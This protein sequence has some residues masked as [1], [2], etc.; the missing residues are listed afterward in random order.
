MKETLYLSE[1]E[2]TF[3]VETIDD[4]GTTMAFGICEMDTTP[5]YMDRLTIT[6]DGA[7]YTLSTQVEVILGEP[8]AVYGNFNIIDPLASATDPTYNGAHEDTGEPF[9][10]MIVDNY[11]IVFYTLSSDSTHTISVSAITPEFLVLKDKNGDPGTYP[12][13]LPIVIPDDSGGQQEYIRGVLW[14]EVPFE[15]YFGSDESFGISLPYGLLTNHIVMSKPENL[16]PENIATGVEIAGVTGTQAKRKPETI[17]TYDLYM[18]N[19]NQVIAP[20]SG[21]VLTQVTITKPATLIP[22]NIKSGVNIGGVT[23]TAI[24]DAVAVSQA[25]NFADGDMT[26][27]ASDTAWI[28][29]VTINKPETLIPENIAEGVEI[30]G[31][32]GTH[33]GGASPI[34]SVSD[35]DELTAKLSADNVGCVY[36]YTGETN[37]TYTNGDL[38]EVVAL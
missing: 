31:V 17:G 27:N 26:I 2:V 36:R 3:D 4:A 29:S 8:G 35:P 30:A 18:A 33:A 23:G 25:A 21:Y 6:W 19:G 32:T 16:I 5:T 9:L 1:T 11:G 37:S 38:Y 13:D 28:S 20:N 34:E 7:E 22:G 12:M 10:A 14:D 24:T 15:P